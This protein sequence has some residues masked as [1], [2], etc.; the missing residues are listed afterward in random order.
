VPGRGG[1]ENVRLGDTDG[2]GMGGEGM[3]GEGMD[4]EGVGGEGSGGDGTGDLLDVEDRASS[5]RYP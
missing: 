3:D 2:E 5:P 4:G 1:S